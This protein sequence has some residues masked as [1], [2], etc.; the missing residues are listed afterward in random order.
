MGSQPRTQIRK[1]VPPPNAQSIYPTR[2]YDQSAPIC[3]LCSSARPSTESPFYIST[4]PFIWHALQWATAAV[5]D[6]EW[7]ASET[8][9]GEEMQ[10]CG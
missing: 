4:I 5:L 7:P 3:L 10:S 2:P 6:R 1:I 9:M 8:N